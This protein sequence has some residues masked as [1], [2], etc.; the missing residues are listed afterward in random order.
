[1]QLRLELCS[2]ALV[3]RSCLGVRR[4]R[5]RT[6]LCQHSGESSVFQRVARDGWKR[7][8]ILADERTESSKKTYLRQ[9][10]SYL[11]ING[12]LWKAGGQ[13]TFRQ[14]L[15]SRWDKRMM[16]STLPL[17]LLV[18]YLFSSPHPDSTMPPCILITPDLVLQHQRTITLSLGKEL[19]RQVGPL[20]N[21][22][23]MTLVTQGILKGS[24]LGLDFG[25]SNPGP[26]TLWLGN[27]VG[28]LS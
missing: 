23:L 14:W 26:Y 9:L 10:E 12:V 24:T 25:F 20:R 18:W 19:W 4:W 16:I 17:S 5:F 27:G 1:M 6:R 8:M 3:K 11:L 2:N 28:S 7:E 22:V 21:V 15:N 13:Q